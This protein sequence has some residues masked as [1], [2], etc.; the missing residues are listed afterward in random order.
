M[1]KKI[2]YL[3]NVIILLLKLDKK[4]SIKVLLVAFLAIYELIVYI[5]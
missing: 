5:I 2:I 3:I 4:I 1:I